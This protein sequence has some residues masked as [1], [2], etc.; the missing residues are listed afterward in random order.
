MESYERSWLVV[1]PITE[2][3]SILIRSK[4]WEVA[5]TASRGSR[6][7]PRHP[8]R[9][10]LN[11]VVIENSFILT[12]DIGFDCVSQ[13]VSNETEYLGS[14]EQEMPLRAQRQSQRD[15]VTRRKPG[16]GD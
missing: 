12:A 15:L 3:P 5:L 13:R 6:L 8:A 14:V 7:G 2:V 11:V 9:D 10:R 4:A 16:D 1:N